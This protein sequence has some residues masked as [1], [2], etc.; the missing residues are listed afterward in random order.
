MVLAEGFAIFDTADEEPFLVE[1]QLTV[2]IF[3][4]SKAIDNFF[5]NGLMSMFT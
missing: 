1:V 5:M 4:A 3:N 2:A